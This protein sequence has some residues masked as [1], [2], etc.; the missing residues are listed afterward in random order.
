MMIGTKQNEIDRYNKKAYSEFDMNYLE[1]FTLRIHFL[2]S[3]QFL[4]IFALKTTTG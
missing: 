3:E 2:A 1:L 4:T